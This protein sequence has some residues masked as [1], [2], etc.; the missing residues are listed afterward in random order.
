MT[1]KNVIFLYDE[2]QYFFLGKKTKSHYG[3][4]TKFP[5]FLLYSIQITPYLGIDG[6]FNTITYSV[7]MDHTMLAYLSQSK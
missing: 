6:A 4:Q 2:L 7:A 1:I 3:F 5:F